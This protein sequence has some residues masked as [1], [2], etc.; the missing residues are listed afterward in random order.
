MV[1]FE[2]T[3]EEA[4]Q[5]F[6]HDPSQYEWVEKEVAQHERWDAEEEQEEVSV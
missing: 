2:L 4:R 3:L 6:S 1:D 5:K